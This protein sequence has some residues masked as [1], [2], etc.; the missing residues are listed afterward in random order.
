MEL[1]AEEKIQDI[2][3]CQKCKWN[4]KRSR[5]KF[6]EVDDQGHLVYTVRCN[7]CKTTYDLTLRFPTEQEQK[8]EQE[9]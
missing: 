4:M 3:I 7:K 2:T 5:C 8:H 6:V 9:E 1:T